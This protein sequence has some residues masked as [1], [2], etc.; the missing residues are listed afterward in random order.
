MTQQR[1]R[2]GATTLQRLE[3][4][5]DLLAAVFEEWREREGFAQMFHRFVRREAG[6]VGGD[7]EQD[8]VGLAGV[9]A[10]EIITGDRAAGRHAHAP[11]AV[12]SAPGFL[13]VGRAERDVMHAASALARGRQ[14]RLDRDVELRG[15][16]CARRARAAAAAGAAA[17]VT[18]SNTATRAARAAAA[19]T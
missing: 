16:A 11:E 2:A 4:R 13:V 17:T 6:A 12:D 10:A 1:Q 18:A 3:P 9:E 14:I 5:L 15:R 19:T 7:L 8:A